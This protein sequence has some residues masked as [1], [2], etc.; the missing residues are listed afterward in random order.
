MRFSPAE[1]KKSDCQPRLPILKGSCEYN[2]LPFP[3]AHQWGVY[4]L[5]GIFL[6]LLLWLSESGTGT[7]PGW[8]WWAAGSAVC[9]SRNSSWSFL[10]SCPKSFGLPAKRKHQGDLSARASS[11]DLAADSGGVHSGE[12]EVGL[13]IAI[14]TAIPADVLWDAGAG[15]NT[16]F[17]V[18]GAC[19]VYSSHAQPWDKTPFLSSFAWLSVYL[20]LHLDPLHPW[21]MRKSP[22]VRPKYSKYLNHFTCT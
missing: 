18:C 4:S 16:D 9:M 22:K 7:W 20:I 11:A 13:L 14:F 8:G 17:P 2:N 19:R 3:A 6:M 10:W 15:L 5:W 1:I 12:G 21:R